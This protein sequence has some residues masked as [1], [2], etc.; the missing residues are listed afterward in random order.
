MQ[1]ILLPLRILFLAGLTGLII[2]VTARE[3]RPQATIFGKWEWVSTQFNG[4]KP[5]SPA[6]E[7]QTTTLVYKPDST[8]DQYRDGVPVAQNRPFSVRNAA[9]PA[10]KGKVQ[11]MECPDE[12]GFTEPYQ[13]VWLKGA[14]SDTLV[15]VGL[16]PQNRF[17]PVVYSVFRKVKE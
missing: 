1:R 8:L 6:T 7:G 5:L 17:E 16:D 15:F 11:F 2:A 10:G 3:S 12:N 9:H 4:Q 13:T 14:G